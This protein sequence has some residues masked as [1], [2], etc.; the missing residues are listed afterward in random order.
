MARVALVRVMAAV[1]VSELI[2][3]PV[4]ALRAPRYGQLKQRRAGRSLREEHHVV[5][6]IVLLALL[7]L[8]VLLLQFFGRGGGGGGGG[9]WGP[10]PPNGPDD[11]LA[12]VPERERS[13]VR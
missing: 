12:A 4:G 8:V 5:V 11:G 7:L 1:Q 13:D 2:T 10:R 6:I 9:G 3:C